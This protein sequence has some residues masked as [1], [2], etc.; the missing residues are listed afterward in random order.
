MIFN[1][2]D[3]QLMSSSSITTGR[4]EAKQTRFW[5]LPGRQF[6][7]CTS[8]ETTARNKRNTANVFFSLYLRSQVRIGLCS[9][10]RVL[11]RYVTCVAENAPAIEV[12]LLIRGRWGWGKKVIA[13]HHYPRS[14]PSVCSGAALTLARSAPSIRVS[15][16]LQA[17]VCLRP[18]NLSQKAGA[19]T[20]WALPI[21]S[22]GVPTC[23]LKIRA[24][25]P[26]VWRG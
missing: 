7:A 21:R 25:G 5:A 19:P 4:R 8:R 18:A 2:H 16:Y 3:D 14:S 1:R 24:I 13:V 15:E 23:R 26:R 22:A 9:L 10:L 12:G 17:R 11:V 20:G 6:P